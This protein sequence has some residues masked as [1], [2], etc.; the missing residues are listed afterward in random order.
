MDNKKYCVEQKIME[1]VLKND[2]LLGELM[3]YLALQLGGFCCVTWYT[4]K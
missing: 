1:I 2:E 3:L 4:V